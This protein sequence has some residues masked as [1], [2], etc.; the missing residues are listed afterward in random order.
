MTVASGN[1]GTAGA[2]CLCSDDAANDEPVSAPVITLTEG[3]SIVRVATSGS[4]T[5]PGYSADTGETVT[6]NFS[7]VN[8][9]NIGV[10][11]QSTIPR[12]MHLAIPVRRLD[13]LE[14]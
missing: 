2:K 1:T 7:A 8:M 3:T 10:P 4:Y 5:D 11:T 6:V 12:L 9:S 13:R 14:S